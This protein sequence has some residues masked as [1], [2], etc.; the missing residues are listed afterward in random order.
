M[1]KD[2][3]I[4]YSLLLLIFIITLLN[5]FWPD[6]KM[7]VK[8]LTVFLLAFTIFLIK[9]MKYRKVDNPSKNRVIIFVFGLSAIY[10]MLLYIIGIFAGFY[11]NANKFSYNNLYNIILPYI[12]IVVCSEIIRQIFVTKENKKITVITTIVLVLVEITLYLDRYKVW[13]LDN[14]LILIG[15]V[16]FPAISINLMCNYIVKRYGIIPNILY[17]VIITIYMY[18]FSVLPDI[19]MFF[20]S[21]YKIIYPYIIYIA[22]DEVFEKKRFR[23]VSKNEKISLISILISIT[24]IVSIVMLVSCKFKYGILVVGSSSMTGTVDKG[25]AVIFERYDN[26]NLKKGQIIVFTKDNI[27]TIHCIE[28]IQIKNDETIY[29]TKG[30]NNQQR[31]EGY[32]TDSD[33]LGI[34]KFKIIDIGWPT[35]WLN[36][37]FTK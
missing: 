2:R 12:I 16:T 15:Y 23:K 36:D 4:E 22:I 37:I 18:I 17:R 9:L 8:I 32:R 19:Y 25:D 29:F 1:K 35:I 33:I 26:Q 21:I 20:Q 27:K 11:R 13:N 5:L 34:V 7:Q 6:T 31:D 24:I 14:A 28:N 3:I 10:I 30:T